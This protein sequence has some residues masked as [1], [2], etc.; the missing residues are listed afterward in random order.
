MEVQFLPELIQKENIQN[1]DIK[2]IHVVTEPI[3]QHNSR[4][5]LQHNLQPLS[6]LTN[7]AIENHHLAQNIHETKNFKSNIKPIPQQLVTI[8]QPDTSDLV[9]I[10]GLPVMISKT[11]IYIFIT[12][13]II[14]IIYS[15]YRYLTSNSGKND[16]KN[17]KND[18]EKDDEK[19]DEKIDEKNDEKIDEKNDEKIDEKIDEKNE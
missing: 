5:I 4:N 18:E 13:L 3:L 19:N 2:P 8:K 14:L 11:T 7:T 15:I 16:D 1:I 10:F 9:S 17:T 12:F 6:I